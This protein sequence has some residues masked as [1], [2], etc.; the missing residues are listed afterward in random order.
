VTNR[1]E[2]AMAMVVKVVVKVVMKVVVKVAMELG[3][4]RPASAVGMTPLLEHH[5]VCSCRVCSVETGSR[6]GSRTGSIRIRM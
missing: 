6:T 3:Q 2:R 4:S 1:A 5:R